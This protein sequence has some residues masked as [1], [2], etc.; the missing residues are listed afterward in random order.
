MSKP[1]S[2]PIFST[3]LVIGIAIITLGVILTLDNLRW[4]DAWGLLNY[5]PLIL[6][7][8][9]VAHLLRQGILNLGGHI[10]LGLSV[11]GFV[12]Q[13][14]PWGLLDRWSPIFLVWGGLVVTL[15]AIFLSSS[16]QT[17]STPAPPPETAR[18]CDADTPP[19]SRQP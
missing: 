10:W 12:S 6:T 15:R 17:T 18:S 9:G 7:G 5:W 8:I 2:P 4:Y 1:T 3:R 13:F 16:P 19:D 11:A 14:G